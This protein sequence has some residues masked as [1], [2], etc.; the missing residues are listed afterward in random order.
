MTAMWSDA[1]PS[2][3]PRAR[4]LDFGGILAINVAEPFAAVHMD[5]KNYADSVA[6]GLA[7]QDSVRAT[8]VGDITLSGTRTIDRVSVVAGDRVLVKKQSTA[9]A[10]GVC[11]AATG[12]ELHRRFAKPMPGSSLQLDHPP[13]GPRKNGA[14]SPQTGRSVQ[15]DGALAASASSVH[16]RRLR[17]F[18]IARRAAMPTDFLTVVDAAS[19]SK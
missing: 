19:A 4:G 15:S 10:N 3:E 9:S 1:A 8:T 7:P 16:H 12:A 17:F 11:V 18:R 14:A 5:T 2:H 13:P 6:Q